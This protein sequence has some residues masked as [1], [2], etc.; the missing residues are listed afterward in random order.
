METSLRFAVSTAGP[1]FSE[2]PVDAM[3]N[4][5][6]NV[7]LPCTARGSPQ[8]SITWRRQDGGHILPGTGGPGRIMQLDSGH[9][10]IQGEVPVKHYRGEDY[11]SLARA[12]WRD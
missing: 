6:E 3:A 1:L 5:G 9:L 12:D 8:P 4:I 10:L 11:Y 7:T 2:V